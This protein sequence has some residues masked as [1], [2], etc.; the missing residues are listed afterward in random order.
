MPWRRRRARFNVRNAIACAT[1]MMRGLTMRSSSKAPEPRH[2]S[3]LLRRG[4][5]W[6]VGRGARAWSTATPCGPS[7]RRAPASP[8]EPGG[9][10]VVD[11][12]ARQRARQK[13]K[14]QR[15]Q[16]RCLPVF[17][18]GASV[19]STEGLNAETKRVSD[20]VDC[21]EGSMKQQTAAASSHVGTSSHAIPAPDRSENHDQ[22][23][24]PGQA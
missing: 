2:I 12:V 14:P 16:R 21:R 4:V 10:Q 18:R 8:H 19:S 13:R 1:N 6:H 22:S 11:A 24:Q 17:D 23:R 5:Q 20:D 3:H 15:R 7:S 9:R